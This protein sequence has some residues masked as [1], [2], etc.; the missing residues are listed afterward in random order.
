VFTTD[1]RS[2]KVG[3]ANGDQPWAEACWYLWEAREQFR[4]DGTVSWISDGAA[5]AELETRR[6]IWS[7]LSIETRRSFA[8]PT[9]L[10]PLG[11]SQAPAPAVSNLDDPPACFWLMV[12]NPRHV[13]HLELG[14]TPH[15]RRL[16][17]LGDGGAWTVEEVNP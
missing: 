1:S 10:S 8:W 11:S 9:P 12:L 14:M 15:R 13:D 4:I 2:A 3:E 6:R 7:E 16:H 17:S 5:G